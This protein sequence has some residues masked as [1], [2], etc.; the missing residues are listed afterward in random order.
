MGWTGVRA[1]TVAARARLLPEGAGVRAEEE[2]R[3][4]E[5][6]IVNSLGG[7]SGGRILALREIG[8]PR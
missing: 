5:V 7:S 3:N 2:G 8:L 1:R 6:F 4:A